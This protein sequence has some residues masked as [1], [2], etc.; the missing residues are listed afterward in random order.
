MKTVFFW[1][2]LGSQTLRLQL[3][4]GVLPSGKLLQARFLDFETKVENVEPE[5]PNSQVLCLDGGI[6][7]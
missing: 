2:W 6:S 3:G 4:G 5:V 7:S 1:R